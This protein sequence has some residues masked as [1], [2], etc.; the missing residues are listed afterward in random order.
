MARKRSELHPRF[1]EN[2]RIF[3]CYSRSGTTHLSRINVAMEPPVADLTTE[4]VLLTWPAGG[5]N[6]G[7]L[8][9]G[10]DGMLYVSTGDGSGPNPPDGRTA[11]QDVT[12]LFGCILRID[13]DRPGK[14]TA[15]SIPNDNPFKDLEGARP[16]VWSYGL[17]NPWKFGIDSQSGRVFA[18]DN[19]W[20]SWEMIHEIVRGGNCGWPIM[21][22][23][24]ILR[25]E[26]K[27]GP[28]EIR[29][30]VKD[31]PH[32]EANSVIGGPV[33]R[34]TKLKDL[35]GTFVYGD[36]ITGTIWGLTL[37]SD[38]EFSHRTLVDTDQRITAF[39]E[40]R[41]GELYV[42]DYDLTGGIYELTPSGLKD[43]SATFPRKLS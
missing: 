16:E 13:V 34:G 24:A 26:V 5:H 14:T 1:S 22:G 9:F 19:G 20:E 7:C 2:G 10:T 33:Y 18:A 17:R 8:A 25:S 36:Y 42:L 39:A 38:G 43:T 6:G 30:P 41:Q 3:V 35:V 15:Y 11:A 40:G 4:E 21:E 28:T 29:P 27:R 23:R 12:N 31:H 37:E 32:S